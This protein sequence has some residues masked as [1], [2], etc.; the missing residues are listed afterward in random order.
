MSAISQKS[1]SGITSIT[2]PAG[3]DN[4]FTVHTNDTT[5]RFRID[6][7][8]N[9]NIS[10]IVTAT[11]FKSGSSNLH[12]TG[13]TVGDTFVHSTGIN[14]SSADIDDFI[15]V[16]TNIHLGNAG[17][18]TATGADINGDLDVDGHTNLDNVNVSGTSTITGVLYPN[19]GIRV[20]DDIYS[21]FGTGNDLSIRHHAS[22]G[23]HSYIFNHGAGVLKIGSDTQMILGE[24][25][26][27][28]YIQMNPN[29]DVK[30]FYNNSQKLATSN[31]GVTVT[32]TVAATSY[33]GDG[34]NLTGITGTTINNNADNRV[35]TGS[36]SANTLEGEA[37]L[38]YNASS[39][40]LGNLATSSTNNLELMRLE[41]S[42]SDGKMTFLG[43]K[44]AGL[45]SPQTR[46]YGG[47]DN[48]GAASQAGDSGAGKFKVTITNP[49]GTHQEVIYAENDANS[50]S[51][52]LRLSTNG[53][54]RFRI[55]SSGRITKP[56]QPGFEA[57]Y[58]DGY[59]TSQSPSNYITNWLR[60]HHNY[61]SHF[62][63]TNGRFTAPVDGR[64]LIGAIMTNVSQ[65]NPHVAFGINGGAAS[66]PSRGGTNY[67]ETWHSNAGSGSGLS[68]VHVFDLSAND[69][70][71]VW[72][73]NYTGTPDDPRC[74]FFGYLLG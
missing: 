21:Y 60:V 69:Y 27:R 22:G 72:I 11:N 29:S 58:P 17:V 9:Q 52:F 16:G 33:T 49:S 50:A 59:N 66:G 42:H 14:G 67:T 26:P 12:S 57:S 25:G 31:T 10:G 62:N 73:Y 47:N 65:S 61:G 30:L 41:N 18:V 32:G 2:T 5:Q 55:D 63:N 64:Y 48:S 1:I 56:A 53:N 68:P 46:I 6:Q 23:N 71:N 20:P 3:A 28:N 19:N 45:G 36:G 43:F 4:V 38:T 13:L 34:S 35:I 54:E 39:S 74:Y 51:K 15:S 40:L 44:T 24:T 70:V 37:N 7:T 8:G